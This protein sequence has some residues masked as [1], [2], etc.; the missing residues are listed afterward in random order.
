VHTALGGAFFLLHLLD[1]L[2][3]PGAACGADEPGSL[4]TRWNVLALVLE[5]WGADVSD[6]IFALFD[7]LSGSDAVPVEDAAA[8]A[9]RRPPAAAAWFP[10]PATPWQWWCDGDRIIVVDP[11]SGLIMAD[12][13]RTADDLDVALAECRRAWPAS[14]TTVPTV[15]AGSPASTMIGTVESR[16]AHRVATLLSVLLERVGLDISIIHVSAKVD[17]IA[18]TVRVGFD[19]DAVD[20]GVRRAGLDRTPGWVPGLGRIIELEFE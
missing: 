16:W 5:A 11:S 14:A 19:L 6:P 9:F 3:L 12:V 2:D 8:W 20:L 10:P 17:L 15:V 4:L 18:T 1:R 13:P 7:E